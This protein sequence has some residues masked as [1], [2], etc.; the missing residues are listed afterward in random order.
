MKVVCWAVF[1]FL[2]GLLGGYMAKS[3]TPTVH[4]CLSV[5]MEYF[6]EYNETVDYD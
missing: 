3:E 1:W 6:D 2:I 4:E 5:C